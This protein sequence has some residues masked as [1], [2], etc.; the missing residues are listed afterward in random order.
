MGRWLVI[1]AIG[2]AGVTWASFY[3]GAGTVEVLF[4]RRQRQPETGRNDR[5]DRRA[6]PNRD[7]DLW[8]RGFLVIPRPELVG[9]SR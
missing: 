8:E 3:G 9:A 5:P 2:R 4:D 7:T 1:I 6:R